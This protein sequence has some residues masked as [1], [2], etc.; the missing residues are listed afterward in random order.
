[1]QVIYHFNG[2]LRV[3][4]SELVEHLRQ[5]IAGVVRNPHELWSILRAQTRDSITNSIPDIHS[6]EFRFEKCALTCVRAHHTIL[7][8]SDTICDKEPM[9]TLR[10]L[11]GDYH[12]SSAAV[13][14]EDFFEQLVRAVDYLSERLVIVS[15]LVGI[16]PRCP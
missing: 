9:Y 5:I 10:Q 11:I 15:G 7:Q 12:E 2:M 3:L 14:C 6:H 1:M 4:A 16:F 13:S 8:V